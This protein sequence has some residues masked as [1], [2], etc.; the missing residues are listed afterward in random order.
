M[1]VLDMM[2]QYI[3]DKS[4]YQCFKILLKMSAHFE[5][6]PVCHQKWTYENIL[7]CMKRA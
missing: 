4:Y 7:H 5:I 3:R 2:E 6:E 1:Y